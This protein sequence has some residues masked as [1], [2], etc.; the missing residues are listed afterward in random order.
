[1]IV[2]R[3]VWCRWRGGIY[4]LRFFRRI[5]RLLRIAIGLGILR[6]F[7]CFFIEY[8]VYIDIYVV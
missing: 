5:F 4:I 1:M 2:I 8:N 3:I 6:D 7:Y